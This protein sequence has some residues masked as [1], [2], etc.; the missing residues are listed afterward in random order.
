[1]SEIAK[2]VVETMRATPFL[3]AILIINLA[4]LI[5]FAFTLR[6]VGN[7]IAR[8]DAMLERCIK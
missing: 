7:A 1:M 8:R 6:E 2:Q 5:G 4:V 3:L